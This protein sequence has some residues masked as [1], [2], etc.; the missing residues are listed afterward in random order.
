[1]LPVEH[2]DTARGV[3]PRHA[4]SATGA[5]VLSAMVGQHEPGS[6]TILIVD[7]DPSIRRALARLLAC[8][9]YQVES[10][11]NGADKAGGR[12]AQRC[13]APADLLAPH[14]LSRVPDVMA[15]AW[16]RGQAPAPT[17]GGPFAQTARLLYGPWTN[18]LRHNSPHA[19][20]TPDAPGVATL[21]HSPGR[22]SPPGADYFTRQR[23]EVDL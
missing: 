8:E 6:G 23:A 1:M 14:A 7:D 3:R 11:V 9:G 2:P 5:P 4:L 18:H 22:A 21:H 17:P 10:A 15:G 19:R 16:S 13:W 12:P 20:R